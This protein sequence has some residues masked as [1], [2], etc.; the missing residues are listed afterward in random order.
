VFGFRRW[1]EEVAGWKAKAARI[2]IDLLEKARRHERISKNINVEHVDRLTF[3]QRVS[4][5]LATVAGSWSFIL[6]FVAFLGAWIL[7]NSVG[8]ISH[9][10]NYPYILLNLLLSMLAAMQAPVIMM[11]QSRQ[12][13]RD[14]LRAEHDYEVNVKAELEIEQLHVKLD[15]LR[16]KQWENLLAVQQRQIELLEAQLALLKERG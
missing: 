9:W 12:E 13:A 15:E 5:G 16:E 14:R 11:S 10:D 1:Q 6:S 7:I 2:E 4:D 3:G 8:L